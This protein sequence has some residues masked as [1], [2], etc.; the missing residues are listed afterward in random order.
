MATTTKGSRLAAFRERKEEER[1]ESYKG[2]TSKR[3]RDGRK[4]AVEKEKPA[5]QPQESE[6]TFMGL[7]PKSKALEALTVQEIRDLRMIFDAFDVDGSQTVDDRELQR[8]MRLLGFPISIEEARTMISDLDCGRT[9]GFEDF[10]LF[11]IEKQGDDRDIH[12][13]IMQGFD[14]FDKSK[15]GKITVEDLKQVCDEVGE[16]IS[17]QELR[18]MINIADRDG[19]SAVSPKEFIEVMLKTNLFL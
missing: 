13:E 17:E 15:K 9:I 10:L 4:V 12:E 19:D 7:K 11:V 8:A 14:L 1:R 3:N 18:E 16:T 6:K 2:M 5:I